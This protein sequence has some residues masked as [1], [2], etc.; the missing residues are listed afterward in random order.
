[1]PAQKPGVARP[2]G[3]RIWVAPAR[4]AMAPETAMTSTYS[5]VTFMPA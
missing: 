1:M 5:Q 4:P 3:P 2:S